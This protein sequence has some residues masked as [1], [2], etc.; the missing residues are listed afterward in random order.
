MATI[1]E[2]NYVNGIVLLRVSSPTNYSHGEFTPTSLREEFCDLADE[3]PKSLK[4]IIY[5]YSE[6]S[7]CG[8]GYVLLGSKSGKEWWIEC[9]SHNSCDGP[10]E[11]FLSPLYSPARFASLDALFANGT[12]EWGKDIE[13]LIEIARDFDQEEIKKR[14]LKK[15][16]QDIAIAPQREHHPIQDL[17]L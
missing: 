6:G 5:W 10:L 7:Y 15:A 2:R 1:L 13:V 11:G 9:L 8:S 3:Y 16:Q 4:Y 17:E 14:N 12:N